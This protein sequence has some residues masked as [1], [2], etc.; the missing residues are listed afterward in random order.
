MGVTTTADLTNKQVSY[1]PNIDTTPHTIPIQIP[2][3]LE[4]VM[5][6]VEQGATTP[7]IPNPNIVQGDSTPIIPNPI[8]VQG[9]VTPIIP[10]PAINQGSS[11][12][13][14]PN[15]TIT[16]G[17]ITPITTNIEINQGEITPVISNPNIIQGRTNISNYDYNPI[18]SNYGVVDGGAPIDE[19]SFN[20]TITSDPIDPS[21]QGS[22]NIV[23]P[24]LIINQGSISP[25]VPNPNIEQ[26]STTPV[27]PN[28][29][30]NQGFSNII[31]SNPTIIQGETTPTIPNPIINQGETTPTIPNP[32][33]VQGS[34][35]PTT[36]NPNIVQG[37]TTPVIP[38]PVIEQGSAQPIISNPNIVQGETT[39][40]IPNPNIIQGETTP[41]PLNLN[42]IQGSTTPLITNPNIVQ[43]QTTPIVSN[44]NIVQGETTPTVPN[45]NIVQGQVT[46]IL[47]NPNI[48][49]GQTTPIPPTPNIIQGQ[50]TP[51]VS[52]PNIVQ[53]QTTPVVSNA[54][55]NQGN[56]IVNNSP[57]AWQN[58]NGG[59]VSSEQRAA[60]QVLS[61]QSNTSVSNSLRF[62]S[63]QD[64]PLQTLP[65]ISQTLNSGGT[66]IPII[67]NISLGGLASA[68]LGAAG[69]NDAAQAV[70]AVNYLANLPL[71]LYRRPEGAI[72]I[73]NQVANVAFSHF[74]TRKDKILTTAWPDEVSDQNLDTGEVN[75]PVFAKKGVENVL[76]NAGVRDTTNGPVF[77]YPETW[78]HS[79][80]VYIDKL[81]MQL[82]RD[83]FYNSVGP[84]GLSKSP[85]L[86]NSPLGNIG[87]TNNIQDTV[88]SIA[89]YSS[90][91]DPIIVATIS[92][93][94]SAGNGRLAELE[95]GN[96]ISVPYEDGNIVRPAGGILTTNGTDYK[97]L[98]Y[99]E[100]QTPLYGHSV[101]TY[102]MI[103]S[104]A[105]QTQQNRGTI[106]DDFRNEIPAA[107]IA[108]DILSDQK[109][110]LLGTFDWRRPNDLATINPADDFHTVDDMVDDDINTKDFI[111]VIFDDTRSDGVG[112]MQFRS[113]LENFSDRF[114]PNWSDIQ[115]IGRPAPLRLFNTVT[116]DVSFD[117]MVPVLSRGELLKTYSKLQKL[118]K[119]TMPVGIGVMNAPIFKL[120]LGDWFKEEICHLNSLTYTVETEYPWEVNIE[121][122]ND[123]G[124]LP[125]Y[126]K[127][128]MGI[129]IIGKTVMNTNYNVFGDKIT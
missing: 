102:N 55:I 27:I 1:A 124:E 29:T 59:T 91:E 74:M 83:E 7:V 51:I 24:E 58:P 20:S 31:A 70:S 79:N 128:S 17:Q 43:G 105:Q 15:P 101:L 81:K 14:I 53:G 68:G 54:N 121:E 39:P 109:K 127:V 32:N 77:E 104:R 95:E 120:T 11:T 25:I 107:G 69:F 99:T 16:Q 64:L 129:Y 100:E 93:K 28:P 36:P 13:I 122:S 3:D 76:I 26:G 85:F 82:G 65:V 41:I 126:V 110:V 114:T 48:I 108:T 23:A 37:E 96:A 103:A 106:L 2:R 44:P 97:K 5:G 67:G 22:L 88:V 8:I 62:A 60:T 35:D 71:S 116:R 52:N 125:H 115:Y 112:R 40:V 10:D 6:S 75:I 47:P 50:T 92:T 80:Y 66:N 73:G 42:I 72:L 94:N 21:R 30:I 46:P 89:G 18:Q 12:P 57:L 123:V 49:Q 117:L 45:P 90:N 87:L 61:T 78:K 34:T 84:D 56:I 19:T 33:I 86:S 9:E 119:L 4:N 111:R 38:N 113:Y 118:A 98:Y 63:D